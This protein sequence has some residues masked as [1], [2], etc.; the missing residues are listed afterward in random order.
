[1]PWPWPRQICLLPAAACTPHTCA[2][3]AYVDPP[4]FRCAGRTFPDENFKY[5]HTVPGLMSM[6][7]AGPNT[8]GSQVRRLCPP[9]QLWACPCDLL[10]HCLC[11]NTGHLHLP[12]NLPCAAAEPL[13]TAFA[14]EPP[15]TAFVCPK[16]LCLLLVCPAVLHHHGCHPL[17]SILHC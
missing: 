2:S 14:A 7:N 15:I 4:L 3:F 10:L 12:Q 8:N 11:T 6:A 9:L 5:K 16:L 1:M 13:I 17:V